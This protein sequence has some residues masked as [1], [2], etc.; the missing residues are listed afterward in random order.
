[1]A[2][3]SIAKRLGKRIKTLFDSIDVVRV[4]EEDWR[5]MTFG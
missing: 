4:I 5:R 1:L 3:L 2:R